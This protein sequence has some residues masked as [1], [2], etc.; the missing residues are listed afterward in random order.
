MFQL[1]PSETHASWESKETESAN[2]QNTP[3]GGKS[4]NSILP[5]SF[6]LENNVQYVLGIIFQNT[7]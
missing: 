2:Q 7:E 6:F 4:T 1:L 3:F 5:D